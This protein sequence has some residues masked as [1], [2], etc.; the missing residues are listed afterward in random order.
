MFPHSGQKFGSPPKHD[1]AV[2]GESLSIKLDSRGEYRQNHS[3]TIYTGIYTLSH[4]LSRLDVLSVFKK[5]KIG[6][7][8]SMSISFSHS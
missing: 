5:K 8:N 1:I 3:N 4:N 7:E 2:E 6:L